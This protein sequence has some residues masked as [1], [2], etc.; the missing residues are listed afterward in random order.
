MEKN[1][2]LKINER[3][4]ATF[5]YQSKEIFE[6]KEIS[7]RTIQRSKNVFKEFQKK[8][9]ILES[10]V[11]DVTSSVQIYEESG[12]TAFSFAAEINLKEDN[13]GYPVT[14][15]MEN[16]ME[17][18]VAIRKEAS[19]MADYQH[20]AWWIRPAFGNKF[21]EIPEKTQLIVFNEEGRYHIYLAVC[22]EENRADLCGTAEGVRISLSSNK[23]NQRKIRD[24]AIIYGQGSDPY[25]VIERA[26][27]LA[28]KLTMKNLKPRK[29]KKF[30]SVFTNIGWCTWDSLGQEVSE[31][32]ILA[33]MDE[34]KE[35]D[36]KIPWVLIDD[37]WSFV[38]KEHMTLK[39]L[40][41]DPVKFPNGIAGTVK[42]LKEKY[43][44]LY[45]GVWQALKGY[46]NGIEE[47][48]EAYQVMSP[49]IMKYANG[50]ISV[51]ATAKDSFGFWNHWHS[52]LRQKGIDFVKV[53]GQSSFSLMTKGIES[54]GA[55]MKG[56]HSG[57]DASI[58]LNFQGN[59]IN[60]M[61]MAPENIWNRQNS[62]VSR[63]SDDF[64][65][66][67]S[68]SF[69][70]HALQNCYNS[71]YHGELYY[72]DWDMFWSQHEDAEQNLILRAISGGPVYFSDA[73]GNTEKEVL[74]KIARQDGSLLKCE[75]AGKP[76]LDCLTEDALHNEQI[77]KVFNE[78]KNAI[79]IACFTTDFS[80]KKVEGSLKL[81]NIPNARR[82]Q[83]WVYDWKNNKL[84][85]CS[86][87]TDYHFAMGPKEA[88]MFEM[89]PKED[90][91]AVLGMTNKYIASAGVE[92]LQYFMNTCI[93]KINC[94]GV[95]RFITNK[96]VE[97]IYVN[98]E[99]VSFEKQNELYSI[100]CVCE[101]A[102]ITIGYKESGEHKK[103]FPESF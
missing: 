13:I 57:L 45:V 12:V 68:G 46:W 97:Y 15:E 31:E 16:S 39:G 65:P 49:Y 52:E 51:K 20:K 78:C 43:H 60:C 48:S 69:A 70:E 64:T 9:N 2:S 4:E 35:K 72:G 21:C 37:G 28:L 67:I 92:S 40:D 24:T 90:D 84:G 86:T 18:S 29:E 30:P 81:E 17:I 93:V 3:N 98:N 36:I 5:L 96:V 91:I 61:G 54:Y 41:A 63:T 59:L 58:S 22:G 102:V 99:N 56:V 74:L 38:D 73:V 7:V 14:L 100:N 50:E 95:F 32:A 1:V 87:N 26:V 44:V 101:R 71:V 34:F 25:D 55:S 6:I 42:I 77:L 103:H 89:V 53:D 82:E 8:Q 66:G 88:V 83:Y 47:N 76:M 75:A 19:F 80:H 10:T 23:A 62:V 27:K 79:Y 33:K 11:N 94:S 85:E